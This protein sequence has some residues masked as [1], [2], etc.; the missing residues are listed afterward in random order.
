[1]HTP[2]FKFKAKVWLY[3]GQAAWH[4]ITVP[5]S[6]SKKL[7]TL[8]GGLA[9]GWGSLPVKATV[10]KTSWQTSI[11][12]DSKQGAYLLPIKSEVRKKELV[13]AGDEINIFL[14]ILA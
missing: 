9:R 6:T 12:P 11:F 3:S 10:G 5:Q 4:F 1:M 2:G 13:K 14:E 8:F 7:K